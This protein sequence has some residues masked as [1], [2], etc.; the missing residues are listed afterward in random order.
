MSLTAKSLPEKNTFFQGAPLPDGFT[1][2][3]ASLSD[4][5]ALVGLFNAVSREVVGYDDFTVQEL[6]T[7]LTSEN[8]NISEDTRVVINPAGEIVA[9]QDVFA[10]SPVPVYPIVWGRTHPDYMGQG[11]STH[12]LR[13]GLRRARHVL[14]KVPPEARVAART[15]CSTDWQPAYE[16]LETHRFVPTRHFYEMRI[17]MQAPPPEPVWPEGIELV[18][19]PFPEGLEAFYRTYDE[20]FEDHFGHIDQPIEQAFAVWKD[21]KLKDEGFDPSLWFQAMDGKQIA[22]FSLGRKY[23]WESEQHG[24]INLLGVRR[25]WRKR[26]L[27]LAL[28]YH[29]FQVYWSRGQRT[30]SLGVDAESITGAVRLY[31]KAGM[32]VHHQSTNFELELRPGDELAN[33]GTEA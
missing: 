6:T 1:A 12:L 25:P 26:G 11:I 27:G 9:Y 31:Q 8:F 15:F 17:E 29:L 18:N 4:V 19:C 14:D 33:T 13:W 5:E 28:L 32:H 3:P 30:V 7:D 24:H 10:I 20:V 16:L 21:Q 23:G 2:R 22:G